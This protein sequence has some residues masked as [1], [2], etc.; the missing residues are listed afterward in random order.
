MGRK[1]SVD[2]PP[3][4]QRRASTTFDFLQLR[5]AVEHEAKKKEDDPPP[6]KKPTVLKDLDFKRKLYIG[7][8]NKKRMM[9]QI[10]SD[11]K[12]L[13]TKVHNKSVLILDPVFGGTQID[14]LQ[15]AYRNTHGGHATLCFQSITESNS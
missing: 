10:A 11:C 6:A 7:P 4:Q 14:G 5:K 2:P 8:E 3:V 9:A 15:L 13:A 1:A 12:V